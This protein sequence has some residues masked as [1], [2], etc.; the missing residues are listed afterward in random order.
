M[1]KVAIDTIDTTPPSENTN[2]SSMFCLKLVTHYHIHK[3]YTKI[4]PYEYV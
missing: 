4:D 3:K 1:R 2:V